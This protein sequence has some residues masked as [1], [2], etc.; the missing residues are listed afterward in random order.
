MP[1]SQVASIEKNPRM[2]SVLSKFGISDVV[3]GGRII[4]MPQP[5]AQQDGDAWPFDGRIGRLRYFALAVMAATGAVAADLVQLVLPF[6]LT[7]Q[8]NN[9]GVGM[10]DENPDRAPIAYPVLFGNVLTHV[11]AALCATA[12]IAR[13]RSDSLDIVWPV[14]FSSKGSFVLSDFASTSGKAVDNLTED[15]EG[16]LK[17]GLLARML[18]VLLGALKVEPFSTSPSTW[19]PVMMSTIHSETTLMPSERRW[20]LSC[21]KLLATAESNDIDEESDL[22]TTESPSLKD[23]HE[24][25]ALTASAAVSFLSDG[26]TIMQVLVP[27]VMAKYASSR[28][29]TSPRPSMTCID[30]LEHMLHFLMLEPVDAMIESQ[31]F[32][33]VAAS[34][35]SA[36]C[37]YAKAGKEDQRNPELRSRLFRSQGFRVLDWPSAGLLD[38][39]FKCTVK[40]NMDLVKAK[41]QAEH[42]PQDDMVSVTWQLEPVPLQS[43]KASTVDVVRSAMSPSLL[44]FITKKNVSLLGGFSPETRQA[45][46]DDHPRVRMIPI[47][48]TDLYA[49]LGTLMPECEQT[50][51]CLICGEVLNAGGKGEC[52]QHSYKCGAGSGMFFLL[53]ECSGLIVHKKNAAYIHSP[54]VDSHGETPQY[55]GRPLNLDLDRYELLREVWFSHGVRQK[56]V[57]ERASARQV[58]LNDFY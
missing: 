36:A 31:R 41:G 13:A 6:P 43:P 19:I 26:A 40:A 18:Q 50:A 21:L 51:V 10:E 2:E 16:F 32:K 58:I 23:L 20:L 35:F 12:G 33:Q 25:C 29:C 4:L 44:S 7:A 53:Q 1:S 49:E 39:T 5:L 47:S 11:V 30:S 57:A 45:K 46:R 52:T 42:F 9:I 8:E 56:V 38:D 55:R 28:L 3:C 17:L 48:Y 54:Y 14:P 24:A 37:A 22:P 34:W 15:C 27:G